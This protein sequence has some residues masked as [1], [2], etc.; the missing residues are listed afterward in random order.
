MECRH[1]R[2]IL[3]RNAC[4]REE[5][6]CYEFCFILFL[7]I[8]LCLMS[9]SPSIPFLHGIHE[10]MMQAAAQLCYDIG[11]NNFPSTIVHGV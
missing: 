2:G 7:F 3:K 11:L 8:Y 10:L 1:A 9:I 4:P 5:L 6:N